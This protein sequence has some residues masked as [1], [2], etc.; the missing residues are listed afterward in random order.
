MNDKLFARHPL[1]PRLLDECW[2]SSKPGGREEA[3]DLII[4][5]LRSELVDLDLQNLT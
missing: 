5:I 1:L 3:A 2:K 4:E